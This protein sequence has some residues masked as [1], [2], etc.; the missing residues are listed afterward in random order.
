MSIYGPKSKEST[1]NKY[2]GLDPIERKTFLGKITDGALG[3]I[4]LLFDNSEVP[5]GVYWNWKIKT[6][7]VLFKQ[8][9]STCFNL[10]KGVRGKRTFGYT[11]TR[12]CLTGQCL[13]FMHR[14]WR[15]PIYVH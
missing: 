7:H 10:R 3:E 2:I 15:Q 11:T 9:G 13:Q 1:K 14:K 4:K 8:R 5:M 6:A 12:H